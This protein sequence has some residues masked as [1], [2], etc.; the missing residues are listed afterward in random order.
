MARILISRTSA[1]LLFVATTVWDA[2]ATYLTLGHQLHLDGNPFIRHMDWKGVAVLHAVLGV[3]LVA[4]YLMTHG[5]QRLL[6]PEEKTGFLRF[7]RRCVG[8]NVSF[9]LTL[10]IRER[11]YAAQVLFWTL[12]FA[13]ASAAL[14]TTCPLLGGPS[15]LDMARMLGGAAVRYAQNGITLLIAGAAFVFA[16][17]P[18]Y[19]A[20]LLDG[21][22]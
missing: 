22:Q 2:G 7:L 10:G 14:I 15:F 8:Q 16:H 19:Q 20:Y 11:V 4:F 18:L 12:I 9:K 13:H 5:K 1:V 21:D 17:Y 6:W 3:L